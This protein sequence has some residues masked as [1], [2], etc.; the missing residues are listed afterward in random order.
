MEIM[1]NFAARIAY[2]MSIMEKEAL[3][4]KTPDMAA[5]AAVAY[6]TNTYDTVMYLLHTMPIT[7]E[8][9][10]QVA[11]RLT[12]EV[13]GKNLSRTFSQLDHLASLPEDWD[14][15]GAL[16]ISRKV[17]NNVKQVLAISDDSDWEDWVVS[18]GTN[19]TLYLV[20][21]R[22]RASVSIGV[23]EYSYYARINGKDIGE[24]H[25]A[26]DSAGLL[27]VMQKQTGLVLTHTTRM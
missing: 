18:P 9:K 5:E 19:A 8:V 23:D 12:L 11:H 1:P 26:Y 6:G 25:I 27:S 21:E 4:I 14:G 16:P 22:N 20:S 10:K 24:N 3:D 17:I 13:T 2:Q 15:R 7:L